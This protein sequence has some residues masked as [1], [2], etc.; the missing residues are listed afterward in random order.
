LSAAD[1]AQILRLHIA[2]FG[3][4][5]DKGIGTPARTGLELCSL[6]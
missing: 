5:P 3:D 6:K 1:A 2:A 4:I